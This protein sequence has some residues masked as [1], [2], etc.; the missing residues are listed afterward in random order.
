MSRKKVLAVAVCVALIT[1]S[2]VGCTAGQT[3]EDV[4][5]PVTQVVTEVVTDNNGEAVTEANGEVVTEVVTDAKGEM[6]TEVVSSPVTVEIEDKPTTK[7]VTQVVTRSNGEKVTN[8]NGEAVTE[9]V[10]KPNGEVV[11]EVVSTTRQNTEQPTT[12]PNGSTTTSSGTTQQTTANSSNGNSTTNNSTTAGST[13]PSNNTTTSNPVKPTAPPTTEEPIADNSISIVLNKNRGATCKSPNVSIATGEIIIDQ[14]GDYVITQDTSE[15]WHGQIIIKLKNTEE[16]SFRFEN[17]H[18]SNDTKNIIQILDS[19][20]TSSR[21]FL[22]AEAMAGTDADDEIATVADNDYAPNVS[23]SFPTGTS[24][25]LET[26]ANAYTGVI[27]NESKLTIKGNGSATI[28]SKVNANNCICSTKSITVK[29]VALT[30]ETAQNENTESL[31]KT[32]GSAK[33]IFSYSKVTVESGFLNVKSNGDGIRCDRFYME[34]GTANI[35]SSA[36]D[37]IDA[38]DSIIING[39]TISATA[40]Q[41]HSFKVRRVNNSESMNV[42]G[43]VRAGKGDCF[44]INGGKVTGE[45]AKI[46]SLDSQFQSDGKGSAQ[47]AVLGKIIKQNAGTADAMNESKVPAVIKIGNWSSINKCTKFLYSSSQVKK[48]EDYTATAN[49]NSSNVIWSNGFGVALI[50]NNTNQ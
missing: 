44:Q 45:G 10:T 19:S 8:Q 43:Q 32:S 23:L 21:S 18:I 28:R 39:G 5:E 1:A 13:G 29:N 12:A 24:S 36:C 46:S 30:L 20:I 40:L 27:Y 41:K 14:P 17:V 26:K 4:T 7:V 3:G 9:V 22:E 31:A 6:V 47:P 25:T 15:P 42:T 11:T 37:G 49:G 16:A 2:F 38:D 33:G 50:K 34:S 35:K 48:G